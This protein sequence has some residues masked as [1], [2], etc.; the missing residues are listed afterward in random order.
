MPQVTSARPAIKFQY[1]G[2]FSNTT[3]EIADKAGTT[4]VIMVLRT[5]P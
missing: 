5:G 1:I 3:A 2:S 4:A